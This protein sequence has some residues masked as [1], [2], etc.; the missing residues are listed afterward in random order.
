VIASRSKRGFLVTMTS[1]SAVICVAVFS[2]CGSSTPATGPL[3]PVSGTVLLDGKPLC[4]AAVS[5]LPRDNTKGT[6]AFGATDENGRY[7]LIKSTKAAGLEPGSYAVVFS[8]FALPDGAPIPEGKSATDVGARET[9][10]RHLTTPRE[11][12]AL[13]A[14]IIKESGPNTFDFELKS[15]GKQKKPT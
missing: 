11:G 7:E 5:F 6:G 2:G 1:A 12:P 10:P 4:G 3:F 15:S 14:A 8:K 9:L 13:Y